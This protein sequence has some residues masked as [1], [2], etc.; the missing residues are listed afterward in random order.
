MKMEDL[1]NQVKMLTDEVMK[2]KMDKGQVQAPAAVA[3]TGVEMDEDVEENEEECEEEVVTWTTVF[4]E[5]KVCPVSGP[6]TTLAS[7]LES[8]PTVPTENT[9]L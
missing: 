4:K 5:D 8:P 1:I 6:G 9:L 3:A 7:L 2:M